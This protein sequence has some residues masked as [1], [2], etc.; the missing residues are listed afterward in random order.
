MMTYR[1]ILCLPAVLF[2][3][4][5][6]TAGAVPLHE[7]YDKARDLY[8]EGIAF[9]KSGQHEA[10]RERFAAA[11]RA[12]SAFTAAYSAL[13]DLYF[14]KKSYAEALFCCR[15]AQQLGAANMSRQIGL[16]YYYLHQYENALEAL[17]Q[18]LHE[19]PGNK[20]VPYQLAQLYAQLG[21]Y[22][23]SIHY[24]QQDLL[25][26]SAHTAAWYELGMMWFNVA[27]PAK[28][29]QAF[30]KAASLGCRQDAAFLF[31]TGVAWLQLQ[32]AEK[33]IA[34]LLKAQE[35]QPDD[36]Q[37]LFNLAQ[38]FYSKGDYAAAIAQWEKVLHLQPTNAFAMFMLGK[39]YMGKG[40]MEKGMALCDKAT[41]TGTIR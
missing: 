36:E 17:Q 24:Y 8:R 39:S 33:G 40:E 34:C 10:A 7:W 25:I 27:E 32:Q 18:A 38:A 20:M 2:S 3:M 35:V 11:I 28:A 19:E 41:A 13:G 26:D 31:N 14:E 1:L 30:E 22:R 12:D 5:I 15:K 21:N 4:A 37:V 16:S 6:H 9:R 29:V 23:E